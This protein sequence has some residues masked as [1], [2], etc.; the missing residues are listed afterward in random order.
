[1]IYF[2]KDIVLHSSES[3]EEIEVTFACEKQL[4]TPLPPAQQPPQEPTNTIRFYDISRKDW[5]RIKLHGDSSK[6]ETQEN[7][8][9]DLGVGYITFP[10]ITMAT[11]VK[12]RFARNY[13]MEESR[14]P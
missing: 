11:A 1:M 13:H 2:N 12:L 3:E 5:R 14:A 7:Y 9:Q 4:A 8:H 6:R 10:Q